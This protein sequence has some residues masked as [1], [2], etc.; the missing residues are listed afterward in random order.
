MMTE[1]QGPVYMC[2]DAWL[3]EQPLVAEIALPAHV[4]AT[5]PVR[6]AADPAAI[7]KVADRLLAAKFP[8]L[9]AEYV[10]RHAEG[11]HNLVALAETLG[12]AV[13]DIN[14]RLNFPNRHKFNLSMDKSVFRDAD[15]I[16]S[17]DTRDWEKPTHAI[18]RNKRTTKPL[19]PKGCEL[20]ELGFGDIGLSKWSMDYTAHARLF[21]PGA[22]GH[23]HRNP[24]IDEAVSEACGLER[25]AWRPYRQARRRGQRAAR[26][27]FCQMGGGVA[28]G[29][30]CVPDLAAAARP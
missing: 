9:L 17:L 25:V 26:C 6:M 11:F 19:Y 15:L 1:P 8:V 2:Y 29:L 4:E 28:R 22:R 12:A 18:D 21:A 10:G 5:T 16:L 3:Q 13:Y 24:G 14:G 27:A 23:H 7:A 20:I 30:G